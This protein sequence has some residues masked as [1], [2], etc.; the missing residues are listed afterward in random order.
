MNNHSILYVPILSLFLSLSA[1]KEEKSESNISKVKEAVET[2]KTVDRSL[3]QVKTYAQQLKEHEERLKALTPMDKQPLIDWFPEK[4]EG[5]PRVKM[6]EKRNGFDQSTVIK[7]YYSNNATGDN[8]KMFN[9]EV[10]DGAGPQ[11]SGVVAGQIAQR[12]I[13][14]NQQTSSGYQKIVTHGNIEAHEYYNE[15][16]NS[17]KLNFSY[18]DRFGILVSSHNINPEDLWNYVGLLDLEQLKN[19]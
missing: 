6:D 9:V 16:Y 19:L 13:K 12:Q 10:M 3:E 14:I 5:M 2:T 17:T 11:A 1:C 7:G 15:Q 4:V 18:A 8:L